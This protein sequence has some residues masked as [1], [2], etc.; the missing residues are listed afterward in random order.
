M[1]NLS[2]KVQ[3]FA[4]QNSIFK[5]KQKILVGVSGGADSVCLLQILLELRNKYDFSLHIAHVNYNLRGIDSDR[6]TLFVQELAKDNKLEISILNVENKQKEK[7]LENE[8]RNIRYNFFEKTRKMLSYDC[9]AVAHNK[10]DQAE[11]VLMRI[12]RGSGSLG[13]SSMKPISGKIIRPLLST[14]RN[15]IEVFLQENNMCFRTDKSNLEPVFLRNKVRLNLVPYLEKNFNPNI[16]E[17]LCK[18]AES[19]GAEHEY[20]LNQA[21]KIIKI[22]V[23]RKSRISFSAT[24]LLKLHPALYR[25]ALRCIIKGIKSNLNNLEFGNIEEIEKILRSTKNKV[26]KASFKGL[27]IEKRGAI[28]TILQDN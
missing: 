24:E 19:V 15:E 2:K 1:L 20:I 22:D 9:V 6:D 17:S 23:S 13:L 5:S 3:N 16:K 7:N 28:V 25:A 27:K 18:L 8:L 12:I 21:K 11:T 14:P 26:Q 10:D 4:H